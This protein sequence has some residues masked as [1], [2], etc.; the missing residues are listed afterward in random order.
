MSED[1]KIVTLTLKDGHTFSDGTP[2][3]VDDVVFSLERV[4]GIKGNPSFLLADVK[5][6]KV[7]DKTLTLTSKR[8][9][10]HFPSSF[11]MGRWEL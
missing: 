3:T 5:V 7:D 10:Q 1:A 2:V 8:V 6:A 11:P 4:Q 9:I